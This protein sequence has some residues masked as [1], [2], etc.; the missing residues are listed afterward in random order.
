MAAAT[1][2]RKVIEDPNSFLLLPGV[3]DGFSARIGLEVGFDGL[4]M[5]SE[6]CFRIFC[7]FLRAN[8]DMEPDWGGK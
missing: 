5:V 2:L 4:Y 8:I 3:Y 6:L 7:G 1:K